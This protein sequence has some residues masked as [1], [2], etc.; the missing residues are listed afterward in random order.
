MK[1][2]APV[3]P[4]SQKLVPDLGSRRCLRPAPLPIPGT[5]SPFTHGHPESCA[6]LPKEGN[7]NKEDSLLRL[8]TK[9][10]GSVQ[11]QKLV[12]V[13]LGRLRAFAR[14]KRNLYWVTAGRQRQGLAPHRRLATGPSAYPLRPPPAVGCDAL[15]RV[16]LQAVCRVSEWARGAQRLHG[17]V[18]PLLLPV[19]QFPFFI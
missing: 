19:S 7:A 9:M 14:R 18:Q 15:T 3:L 16:R 1:N 2:A 13:N 17:Q 10:Q 12:P 4:S 6:L 5:G 8:A 11:P